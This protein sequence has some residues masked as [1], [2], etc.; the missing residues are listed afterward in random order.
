[1]RP[2]SVTL[3]ALAGVPLV[4]PG[5]DLAA[6]LADALR[7]NGV[8][9][10]D[11]D[12]LV[13]AQKIVSKAEG[14]YVALAEVEPSPRAREIAER[15]GKDARYVEVVLSQSED[16]VKVGPR[17][18]VAGHKLGFVMANAGIDESNIRSAAGRGARFVVARGSRRQRATIEGADSTPPSAS[19]SASSSTTAS[20]GPGATASSASPSA[21]RAR[22]LSSTGSA[23][24]ISSAES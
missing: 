3:H 7:A 5:D 9:L 15:T 18:V 1:M 17:V 8:G 10:R 22:P 24:R 21:R 16:I 23:R 20:G 11:S 13:V 4:E 14:R 19:P 2:L 6:I 12:L